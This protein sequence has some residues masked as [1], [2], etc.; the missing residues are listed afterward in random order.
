MKIWLGEKHEIKLRQLID[1][2]GV[3]W[4]IRVKKSCCD[5]PLKVDSNKKKRGVRKET[6]SQL[7]SGVVA[8]EGYFQFERVVSL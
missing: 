8:I 3:V 5:V 7:L 1:S 4:K 6:V 2:L